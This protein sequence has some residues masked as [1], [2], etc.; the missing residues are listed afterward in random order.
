MKLISFG[1]KTSLYLHNIHARSD[2][3]ELFYVYIN[4][5]INYASSL[6]MKLLKEMFLFYFQV[7]N[8]INRITQK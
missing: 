5:A 1:K 2:R 7:A 8:L 3:S 6:Y 4:K